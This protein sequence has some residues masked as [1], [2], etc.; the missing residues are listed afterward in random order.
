MLNDFTRRYLLHG[1]EDSPIV[2]QH[3]ADQATPDAWDRRPDPDRFTL[4]E[5]LAHMADWDAVWL[6]RLE[7]MLAPDGDD[8][9]IPDHDPGQR[10]LENDYAN[11]DPATSLQGFRA[12]RAELVNRLGNLGTDDWQR[13]GQH[14]V[15]GPFT[16]ADLA[17]TAL[18]HDSY[19]LAQVAEWLQADRDRV[20]GQSA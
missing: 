12:R 16:V 8:A 17:V 14:D 11:A 15:R 5:I 1:M 2:L 7:I 3:L 13:A 9:H 20:G 18:G 10:A 4:R 6:E 19:H